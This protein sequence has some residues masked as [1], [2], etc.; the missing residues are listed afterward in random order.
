[1]KRVFDLVVSILTVLLLLPVLVFISIIVFVDMRGSV[2]FKQ[3]RIGKNEKVFSI[4]KFKTMR[5]ATDDEGNVLSNSI[6]VTKFGRF[7]RKTSLDE[8]PSLLNIIVGNMS[9]VGPRPLLVE[10]LPYY[11][12]SHRKRHHVTPGLTGLAQVS[13]R[14]C[15]SWNKR[16]DLD[17]YYVENS[18]LKLDANI[19]FMTIKKVIFASDVEGGSDLSIVRLDKDNEYLKGGE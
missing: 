14:N 8:L 17:V 12:N 4:L 13:G 1:M 18:S 9:L 19:L 15:I 10:Y 7:L 6:R 3:E 16:L 11:K 5:D 2:L